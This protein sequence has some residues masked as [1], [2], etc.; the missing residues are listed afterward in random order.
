[1]VNWPNRQKQVVS[2]IYATLHCG[3]NPR[4]KI[5]IGSAGNRRRLSLPHLRS[6]N[7]LHGFGDLSRVFHRLYPSA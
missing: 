1:V 5:L 7:H 6:G 2:W 4:Q 3:Q